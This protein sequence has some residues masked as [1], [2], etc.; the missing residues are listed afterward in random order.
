LARIAAVLR[1]LVLLTRRGLKSLSSLGLNNL[2]FCVLFLFQGSTPKTA[3]WTALPFF[4]ILFVPLLFAMAADTLVLIPAVR[5]TLW[6]LIP[7]ERVVIRI[8]GL[9]L[10]PAFWLFGIVLTL[11]QGSAIGLA[12]VALAAII[13]LAVFLGSR[14]A[15]KFQFYPLRWVPAV[16]GRLGGLIQIELRHILSTLD[17]YTALMLSL[18]GSAY[19]IFATSPQPDPFPVVAVLIAIALSTIAQRSFGLDSPGSFAR[20]RLLPLPGWQLLLA[21]DAA[22]LAITAVLVVPLSFKAGMTFSFLALAIGRYPSLRQRVPQKPWRF[23]SGDPR[24]GALQVIF[25]GVA[26]LASV[27]TSIGFLYLAIVLYAASLY[28]GNRWW[29]Q[30]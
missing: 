8:L 15:K 7:R 21:K 4:V 12:F 9:A 24:F 22:Y 13:Q 14:L 1:L 6:P 2:F 23:T 20:Y 11:W 17:V 18:A 10:S 27:R 26:G 25:G 3:F 28:M 5:E 16:P 30:K 19:R 29:R